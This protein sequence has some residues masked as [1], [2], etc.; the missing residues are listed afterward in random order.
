MKIK[1][2]MSGIKPASGLVDYLK[3][4]MP[5]LLF[6][7]AYFPYVLWGRRSFMQMAERMLYRSSSPNPLRLLFTGNN[8][9]LLFWIAVTAVVMLISLFLGVLKVRPWYILP[10]YLA[11]M[12]SLC[13]IL[14]LAFFTIIVG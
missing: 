3:L 7:A 2:Y 12:F 4:C 13:G 11:V 1:N 10:L 6:P 14:S 9:I 5:I 8:T